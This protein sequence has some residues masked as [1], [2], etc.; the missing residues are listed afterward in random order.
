MH[1]LSTIFSALGDETRFAIVEQLLREG[2]KSA[3]ELVP[4]KPMSEPARSR[5]LKVLLEAGVVKR[6]VDGQR[7][8]YRIDARAV[9]LINGWIDEHRAWWEAALDRLQSVLE[10]ESEDDG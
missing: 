6:R 10:Q 2:E 1:R 9:G 8:L 4:A 5:H 7:R 3:G